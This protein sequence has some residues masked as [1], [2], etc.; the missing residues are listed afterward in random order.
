MRTTKQR[1]KHREKHT[2]LD[3][4]RVELRRHGCKWLFLREVVWMSLQRDPT[5]TER[6]V[7]RCTTSRK[8]KDQ[9]R[10]R[11]F[12]ARRPWRPSLKSSNPACHYVTQP[13]RVASQPRCKLPGCMQRWDR[14][15]SLIAGEEELCR[16]SKT[17]VDQSRPTVAV[18]E[19]SSFS[20]FPCVW[21]RLVS[22]AG[23]QTQTVIG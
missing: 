21:I 2:D 18:G 5:K 1:V 16:T 13:V 14:T 23:F 20:F 15:L 17:W 8:R 10:R 12:K 4:V 22:G 11:V 3:L 19:L 7:R 6:S 9:E